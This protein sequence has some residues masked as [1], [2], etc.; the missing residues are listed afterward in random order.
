MASKNLMLFDVMIA[1][2]YFWIGM[3]EGVGKAQGGGV[4]FFNSS[5]FVQGSFPL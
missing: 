1:K 5:R 2:L 4:F 3:M